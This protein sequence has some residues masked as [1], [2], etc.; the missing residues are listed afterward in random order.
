[1][2]RSRWATFVL[3]GT[4]CLVVG[5]P[6]WALAFAAGTVSVGTLADPGFWL[7]VGVGMASLLFGFWLGERE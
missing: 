7:A 3:V 4:V 5:V 2:S 6:L 1:V